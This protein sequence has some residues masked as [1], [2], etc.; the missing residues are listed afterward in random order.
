VAGAFACNL[1]IAAI[2]V[3][4]LLLVAAGI[5]V[6]SVVLFNLVEGRARRLGPIDRAASE[7]DRPIGDG[8][9]FA[10]VFRHRYQTLMALLMV[11]LNWTNS[12]GE[13]ILGSI[14]TSTGEREIAAGHL[15]PEERSA[16]IGQFYAATSR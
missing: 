5:L 16:F 7:A 9:P 11:V 3:Y 14:V 12:T 6:V 8:N 4:P 2:G 10:I 1:L 13:Y 15:R